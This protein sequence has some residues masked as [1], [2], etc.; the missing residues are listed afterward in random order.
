MAITKYITLDSLR[1]FYKQLRGSNNFLATTNLYGTI[2]LG[3]DMPK[4]LRPLQVTDQ[5][6]AYIELFPKQGD[7]IP[8]IGSPTKPMYIHQGEFVETRANVGSETKPIY[9]KDG[10]LTACN[11]IVYM[12]EIKDSE[13]NPQN[14]LA[15][16][17]I[18]GIPAGTTME[19]LNTKTFSQVLDILLFP[20]VNPSHSNISHTGFALN[21]TTTPV[22]K[23][24][25]IKTISKIGLS[26]AEW[27]TYNSNWHREDE[28]GNKLYKVS[29]N[30]SNTTTTV[31]DWPLMGNMMYAGKKLGTKY[32][33]VINGK[34]ISTDDGN[35]PTI[36]DTAYTT[37]GNHYYKAR[38]QYATGPTPKNNKGKV[39]ESL[40]CPAGYYPSS[41]TWT[42]K[43]V[44]VTLPWFAP[45]VKGTN[46]NKS[47]QAAGTKGVFAKQ[48]L[49]SWNNN[50]ESM[51]T[52]YFTLP[53]QSD[54]ETNKKLRQSFYIPHKVG[55]TAKI[56]V[57]DYV[58]NNGEYV[59]ATSQFTYEVVTK[60]SPLWDAV[61][62]TEETYRLYYLIDSSGIDP[63][64][65]YVK[66]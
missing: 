65:F 48:A 58:A 20:D 45:S 25:P 49:I 1:F 42:Q 15:A 16:V 8:D 61:L 9:L 6:N 41:T 21:N 38:I 4:N 50:S 14:N 18:G 56:Y 60:T 23:G 47:P 29:A 24:T 35:L 54:K 33:F 19:D 31:T 57:Y 40:A 17:Q 26:R 32:E 55:K 52:A 12:T 11:D 10:V 34:T 36:T 37:L 28:N 53:A 7:N 13:G 44:N 39:M 63:R 3:G 51:Q 66:F 2:K 59:D 27:T 30:S 43:T 64:A 46:T 62:P 5:G 22:E